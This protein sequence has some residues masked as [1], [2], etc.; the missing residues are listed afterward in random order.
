MLAKFAM[1]TQA[2]VVVHRADTRRSQVFF[3]VFVL[4]LLLAFLVNYKGAVGI[5]KIQ[6]A[7][8][9]GSLHLAQLQIGRGAADTSTLS[10]AIAYLSIVWPALVFGILISAALR[11]SLSRTPLHRVFGRGAVRDQLAAAL[12]GAPLMLC[13]CCAAPIF[14]AV[15]QRTRKLAPALGMTLASPS[16]N[17]AALT[18]SF[19]LFPWRIAAGRLVMA[20]VLVLI[21]CVLVAQNARPRILELVSTTASGEGTWAGL[22]AAYAELV[23]YISLR[24]VPLILVGIW[25][26]IWLMSRM[27]LIDAV[28]GARVFAIPIIAFICRIADAAQLV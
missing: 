15:Y 17:P 25:A 2:V 24:T 1:A 21:G 28:N 22:L 14:L 11:T 16:L 20:L 27:P 4:A 18:L 8:T 5:R 19:I 3:Q 13:S 10:T 26:S 12:T 9:T 7:R 23:A 6:Q